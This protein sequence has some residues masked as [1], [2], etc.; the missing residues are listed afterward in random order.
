MKVA[1][2]FNVNDG[3]DANNRTSS[4]RLKA[5]SNTLGESS[6]NAND[7]YLRSAD[8]N[9][10]DL[11]SVLRTVLDYYDTYYNANRNCLQLKHDIFKSLAYLSNCLFDNKQQY[12]SLNEKYLEQFDWLK[13]FI[14]E[15]LVGST[16]GALALM[17]Q[18]IDF[19]F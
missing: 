9:N 2:Y 18:V 3:N 15:T 14:N 1:E 11:T 13:L 16:S 17:P 12:E 5:L 8:L 19:Q 7:T 4:N 6:T 10:L